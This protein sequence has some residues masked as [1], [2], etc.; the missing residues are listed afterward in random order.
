MFLNRIIIY[1]YQTLFAILNPGPGQFK[2]DL[3]VCIFSVDMADSVTMA[4][5]FYQIFMN[6]CRV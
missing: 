5:S 4:D 3:G 1:Y 2:H 6:S